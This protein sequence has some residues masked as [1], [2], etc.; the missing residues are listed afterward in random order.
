MGRRLARDRGRPRPRR[1]AD[2]EVLAAFAEGEEEELTPGFDELVSL[3]F[4][5]T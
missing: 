3:P 2:A 1:S 4:L 5:R